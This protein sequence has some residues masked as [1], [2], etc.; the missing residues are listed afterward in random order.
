MHINPSVKAF[1]SLD[2]IN[3]K[4]FSLLLGH[5][6]MI[7]FLFFG[8]YFYQERLLLI[9]ASYYTYNILH[10]ETFFIAHNRYINYFNQW[11]PL[12]LMKMGVGLKGVLI[13]YSVSF[14]LFYYAVFAIVAH[15]F[16]NHKAGLFLVITLLLS[17][18]FKHYMA[19]TETTNTLALSFLFIGWVT[20]DQYLKKMHERKEWFVALGL[21]L[22][23]LLGHPIIFLPMMSFL[24]FY[25]VF[26]K[27]MNNKYAWL[28]FSFVL[29]AMLLRYKVLPSSGYEQ[30]KMAAFEKTGEI[31]PEFF[32]NWTYNHLKE[33]TMMHFKWGYYFYLLTLLGLLYMRR[34][35]SALV[36]VGTLCCFVVVVVIIYYKGESVNMLESY[37]TYFGYF[38]GFT[39]LAVFSQIK[40]PKMVR[41]APV[42]IILMLSFRSLFLHGAFFTERLEYLYSLT[43][44]AAK[45]G[46]SKTLFPKK[47][48]Q[49]NTVIVPWSVS[50]T[51]LIYSTLKDPEDSRTVYL[52]DA[53][54][55]EKKINEEDDQLFLGATFNL[56]QFK[57]KDIPKHYFSLQKGKY[58]LIK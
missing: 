8:F 22:I 23:L 51:T 12:L 55:L 36:S 4:Q 25:I 1:M 54:E 6:G 53:N 21:M 44:E 24:A 10:E 56:K 39:A 40:A 31:L 5:L 18:R 3:E 57:E 17:C 27:Q 26:Y 11:L 19:V 30:N 28:T 48:M 58:Y 43:E 38:W 45:N 9:D 14:I 46:S 15:V 34:F 35:L 33:Y 52:Y 29:I 50:F 42:A 20:R 16:K 2:F 41:F 7:V 37:Y 49:W 47:K 13:G 32:N